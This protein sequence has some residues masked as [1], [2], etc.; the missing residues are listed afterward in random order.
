MKRLAAFFLFSA[1]PLFGQTNSGELHLKVIDPSGAAVK[2]TV[3]IVSQANQYDRTLATDDQGALTVQRLPY[4]I[5]E[6]RIR[7]AGF[8]ALSE[9]IEIRSSIPIDRTMQLKLGQVTESVS[10]TAEN[11][12]INP[13]QAGNVN[14]VGSLTIQDRPTSLPGRSVQDLVNSQPG[15]FY[16]GNAVLHPREAEYQTQFVVD[17]IPLPDNRSPGHGPVIEADDVQSLAVYTAGFPA[18]YGR[19]MGGVV[20]VNTMQDTQPGFHGQAVLSGGS[21]SSADAFAEG[22][23]G[24]GKNALEVSASG[25]TTGHYL[26]PVVPENFNNTATIGDFSGYYQRSLTPNDKL[27]FI[28]RHEFSR[29]GAPNELVQE[30]AGQHDTEDNFE[31]M[32]IVAYQHVF[33]PNILGDFRGMVR[34]NAKNFY[35]DLNSTPIAISQHNYFREGYFKG[36]LTVS[37]GRHEWKVGVESDNL[38]IHETFG[39]LITLPTCNPSSPQYDPSM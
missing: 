33:S 39:W 2:T 34:D 38:F 37:H 17:G 18:E 24:W 32:G 36:A 25:G 15:W 8:A 29:Y 6:L 1:L 30:Q 23:Y 16:E 7:Q 14:H 31:T 11:T 27:S 35:S 5:Y 19:K 21:F 10:V 9:M 22:Q 20:E 12:L 13:D 3:E 28:V 26:N 4:G